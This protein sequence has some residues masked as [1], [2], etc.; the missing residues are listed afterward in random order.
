MQR[1][2]GWAALAAMLGC[3]GAPDTVEPEVGVAAG[4]EGEA[5]G[6]DEV[7]AKVA[8]PAVAASAVDGADDGIRPGSFPCGVCRST[9]HVAGRGQGPGTMEVFIGEKAAA[10][11]R[12]RKVERLEL[13][14]KSA[15]G[16]VRSI[17]LGR[18][19]LAKGDGIKVFDEGLGRAAG[20]DPAKATVTLVAHWTEGGKPV[21]SASEIP[22]TVSEVK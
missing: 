14:V 21:R 16:V 15:E 5:E 4:V 1:W 8:A 17:E 13:A 22:V 19:V 2:F 9:V 3:G 7:A 18:D 20:R 12:A 10:R 11:L 6:E